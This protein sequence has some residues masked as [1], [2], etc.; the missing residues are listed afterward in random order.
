MTELADIRLA[1]ERKKTELDLL[2]EK[3]E[4]LNE[5]KTEIVE[6]FVDAAKARVLVQKVAKETLEE[7]SM[8][9]GDIV[10]QA[11]SA[12]FQ[13]PYTFIVD[14]VNRRNKTECDL[15]LKRGQLVASPMDATGGGVI[16]VASF[17]LRST[18]WMLSDNLRPIL[19]LDEPFKFVSWDLQDYC[20]LTLKTISEQLG[21]QI[22]MV[23]HLNRIINS[24]DKNIE[25]KQIKGISHA[26]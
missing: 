9:V 13:D 10:S 23:T 15:L 6:S 16:D 24:V 11:L 26:S 1:F 2:R 20:A 22:I 8:S 3:Y 17:A 5:R 25:L 18:F 7:L 14:F 4:D 19:I 12:V 21:F